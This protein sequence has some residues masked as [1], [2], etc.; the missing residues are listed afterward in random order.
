MVPAFEM[1]LLSLMAAGL[2]RSRN[3]FR[4]SLAINSP[5]VPATGINHGIS[6]GLIRNGDDQIDIWWPGRFTNTLFGATPTP[7]TVELVIG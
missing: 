3:I 2:E 7:M 5:V 4:W 6:P 1:L